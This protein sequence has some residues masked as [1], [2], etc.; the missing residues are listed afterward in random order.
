MTLEAEALVDRRRIK[1]RLSFWR[2]FAIVAVIGFIVSLG[3]ALD[4]V[5]QIFGKKSHIARVTISGVIT[6][7]REQIEMLKKLAKSKSVKAVIVRINSPGGTTTGGEALYLGLRNISK[8]KPVVA[9]FGTVAASAGYIVGLASDHIVSRGNTITGSVGVILQWAEVTELLKNLGVKVEEIKSGPLKAV[10]SPFRPT[11]ERAREITKEMV[12]DSFDWFVD[13]VKT[14]RPVDPASINGLKEGRVFTGRQAKKLGLVDDIGGEE[15]ALAYLRAKR[16]I[17]K[18][19]KVV[20]WKPKS[21][22]SLSP[23]GSFLKILSGVLGFSL[24]G[25]LSALSIDKVVDRLRL[26]GLVSVW[27]PS[28]G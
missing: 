25:V 10:P 1:R 21:A 8:K 24:D 3:A 9:V 28:N 16:G 6:E 7:S 14:R 26:D 23:L 13:L 19:L 5:A 27:H 15:A 4:P 20:D 22:G 17:G 11:G 2:L 18:K 12:A